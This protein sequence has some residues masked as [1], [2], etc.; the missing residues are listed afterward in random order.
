MIFSKDS[1][2]IEA[3]ESTE[4]VDRRLT[5]LQK[6]RRLHLA[7]HILGLVVFFFCIFVGLI[8]Y[9]KMK[10]TGPMPFTA[11]LMAMMALHQL[12]AL[13]AA[14]NEIRTLLAYKRSRELS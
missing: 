12:A 7:L 3:L 8:G 13:G 5:Q 1:E 11:M 14:Q 6:M 2:F 9:M 4:A 10:Q